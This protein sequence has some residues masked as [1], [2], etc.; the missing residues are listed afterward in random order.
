MKKILLAAIL[1]ICS[2]AASSTS[3]PYCPG[4]V[5]SASKSQALQQVIKKFA[6]MN[7]CKI[8]NNCILNFEKIKYSIVWSEPCPNSALLGN[9]PDGSTFICDAGYCY[10]YGFSYPV[11]KYSEE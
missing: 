6:N 1:I 5:V 11:A 10:P 2:S 9:D 3:I 7:D 8:G 4:T